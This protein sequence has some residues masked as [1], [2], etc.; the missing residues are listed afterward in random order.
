MFGF[1]INNPPNP[2]I[3]FNGARSIPHPCSAAP[4][5]ICCAIAKSSRIIAGFVGSTCSHSYTFSTYVSMASARQLASKIDDDT[6]KNLPMTAGFRVVPYYAL[7]R[8]GRWD[9]MLNEP[10]PPAFSAVLRAVWH[11]A[12][13]VSLVAKGQSAIEWDEKSK[14]KV[15]K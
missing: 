12:R 13:G 15:G 1:S 2:V 8:F 3:A 14:S 10:E 7:T 9:E 11:Y 6:L 4:A 5:H